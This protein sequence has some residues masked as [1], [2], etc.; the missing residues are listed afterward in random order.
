MSKKSGYSPGISIEV[1]RQLNPSWNLIYLKY[2][3]LEKITTD[4]TKTK[5]STD[6][7]SSRLYIT[8]DATS[9]SIFGK[10]KESKRDASVRELQQELEIMNDVHL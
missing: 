4:R 3:G 2:I 6:N 8:S 10:M 1:L 9:L 5:R 7:R